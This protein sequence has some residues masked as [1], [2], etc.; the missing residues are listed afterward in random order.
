MTRPYAGNGFTLEIPDGWVDMTIHTF[1]GPS[2]EDPT[3]WVRAIVDPDVAG[4][5]LDAYADRCIL[6]ASRAAPGFR[7]LRRQALRLAG[8][9]AAIRAEARWFPTDDVRFYQRMVYVLWGGIGVALSSH[10]TKKTRHTQGPIVDRLMESIR[11]RV[12]SPPAGAPAT[13]TGTPRGAGVRVVADRFTIDLPEGWTDATVYMLAE[14][15]ESR[16]RRN[17]VVRRERPENEPASLADLARAEVEGLAATVPAFEL[18]HEAPAQ[19]RDGGPTHRLLFRRSTESGG[20]VLQ[21]Q[22]VAL[23]ESVLYWLSLTVEE[24]VREGERDALL[25]V[26]GSFSAAKPPAGTVGAS[27]AGR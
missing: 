14:P 20:R 7:L 1:V 15:D 23:R 8:G 21:L 19:S 10:L 2:G 27:D 12:A 4:A 11:P 22:H 17:L 13:A 9:S 18:V 6:A 3:S 16:F 24:S 5:A 25:A 26:L